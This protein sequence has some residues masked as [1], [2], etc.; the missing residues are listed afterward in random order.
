MTYDQWKTQ[1]LDD[2]YDDPPCDHEEWDV[3]WEGRIHCGRCGEHLRY[4]TEAEMQRYAEW[5]R[6]YHEQMEREERRE[7]LLRPWRWL[8]SLFVRPRKQR[9][10]DDEIPF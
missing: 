9:E 8:R 5:E 3:D 7:R 6:E 1:E 10:L 4:A 2:Y